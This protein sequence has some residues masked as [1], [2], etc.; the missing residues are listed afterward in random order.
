MMNESMIQ[1][2]QFSEIKHLRH[3]YTTRKGGVSNGVF[4]SLNMGLHRGDDEQ[5]VASNYRYIAG[6][7]GIRETD[8]VLSDQI[9]KTTIRQVGRQDCG[10]IYEQSGHI[11][12]VDGLITNEPQV[13]LTTFYADCIPLYFYDPVNK[14]IGMAHA[15]WRGT[16]GHI[17]IKC[18]EA[19]GK[20]YGT[21]AKD[22]LVGIGPGIG[23]CCYEVSEDV[24]K[25][26]ELSFN[27]DIIAKIVSTPYRDDKN[28]LKIKIDLARANQ[29]SLISFGVKPA[30]IEV[31]NLCTK[32]RSDLFF[33]HRVMGSE[34]GSQVGILAM[35]DTDA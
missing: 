8:Y 1:F 2:E 26:F 18:I 33:S 30:S 28:A 31:S 20:A 21:K 17:G 3:C 22:V 24:K 14:A 12:G 6:L 5:N 13:A 10:S 32:C 9:H 34:R 19:M 7:L 29:L 35:I 27:D 16:V 15:G 11:V 25:E 23:G 4:E